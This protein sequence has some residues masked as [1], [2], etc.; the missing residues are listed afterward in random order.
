MFSELIQLFVLFFVI[1]DPPVSFT[2]FTVATKDMPVKNRNK[3]ALIAIS[4]A[5]ALSYLVLFFGDNLLDLFSTNLD[6]FRVAGGIVLG[7]LG[8][9]MALGKS[10]NTMNKGDNKNV[11]A[12]AAIIAT[13]FITGPA[14]ITTIMVVSQDYGMFTTGLAIT[15]VLAL[16]AALFL[17]SN[18]VKKIPSIVPVQVVSTLLGIITLAWGVK[19]IRDG[20]GF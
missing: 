15:A 2:V 9:Q 7:A 1:F 6:D 11:Q 3:T 20:L 5:A 18:L 14:A 17:A 13:P 10:I 16:T 12:V 19:F 4:V 8:L